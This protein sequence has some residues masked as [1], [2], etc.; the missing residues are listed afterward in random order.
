M[1]VAGS[2]EGNSVFYDRSLISQCPAQRFGSKDSRYVF[3]LEAWQV[4]DDA[5]LD[6]VGIVHLNRTSLISGDGVSRQDYQQRVRRHL[7]L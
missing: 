6:W 5:V 1:K 3:Q 4:A 7:Q 2:L